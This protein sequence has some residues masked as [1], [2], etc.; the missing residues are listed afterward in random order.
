MYLDYFVVLVFLSEFLLDVLN[1]EADHP[2]DGN[3]QGPEGQRAQMVPK[4]P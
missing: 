2:D 4:C 3:D 1:D